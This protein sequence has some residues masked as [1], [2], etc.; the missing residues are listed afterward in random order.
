LS[1]KACFL[2]AK[3]TGAGWSR[4]VG[5]ILI[6]LLFQKAG[7]KKQGIPLERRLCLLQIEPCVLTGEEIVI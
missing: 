1:G 2:T 4:I 3:P 7:G 6:D 5:S